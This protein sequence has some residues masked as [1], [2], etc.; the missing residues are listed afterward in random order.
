MGKCPRC[1][2][3]E[4]IKSH[5]EEQV[6]E[7]RAEPSFIDEGQEEEARIVL[8]IEEMD[9]VLG[10]GLVV[11]S[12][13]LLGG[14]PGIG[15]TTLCFQIVSR[16]AEL[17]Y[18]A[19]YVSGEESLK[20]L[21]LRKRR[22]SLRANFPVLVTNNIDDV[23]EAVS[24]RPY[25]L[26]VVDSIQAIF[27]PKIPMT[28]GSVGQ[29][30]D[31]SSRLIREMK[32][33]EIAH[34]L[35]GHVTK[36]GLIA[37]PR[38]LEH[39]VDTV[40]YFEGEKMFPYRILRATKNRFGAVDEIGIF[41]MRKEGLVSVENPS[42]FFLSTD[43][44]GNGVVFPYVS[45]TR[46]ILIE[47]QALAPK[48]YLSIPK[49]VSFGYDTNRL[50]LLLAV[51]EKYVSLPLY[52]RDI[53]VNITGGIR[54]DEPAVDLAVVA[55]VL[56]SF[57]GLSIGRDIAFFGEVGLTGEI[58]RVTNHELRVKECRRNGVRKV[59]CHKGVEGFE[60]VEVIP[61]KDVRELYESILS[62]V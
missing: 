48:T 38:I 55:S 26:I 10:G 13:I 28:Q 61:L 16:V 44:S 58:R 50:F 27:N 2:S 29:I 42:Q 53:Y 51:I 34:I 49:R 20:Q 35:I 37:G 43:S 57:K 54:V 52:D 33:R 4:S 7:E 25:E 62:L 36:E 9:R 18:S 60:G 41:Q 5:V 11:G 3:W 59:L 22:L 23:L 12:S 40:L 8:G 17:G 56:V 31:V 21:Y 14:D 39:M 19:L 24:Q 45:G 1:G 6:T 32:K 15:K 47:V 46:P 30:R